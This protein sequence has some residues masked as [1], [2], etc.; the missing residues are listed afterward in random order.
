MGFTGFVSAQTVFGKIKDGVKKA[1]STV[2]QSIESIGDTAKST[3]DLAADGGTPQQSRESRDAVAKATLAQLFST[4]EEANALFMTS[5]GYAVFDTRKVIVLGVAAGFG[6]GVAVSRKT[7]ART[8]MNMGTG[9][10]GLSFGLG[11]FEKQIVIMFEKTAGF[12]SFIADGYDATAEAGAMLGDDKI[13]EG[14]RF[15]DGRSI[16]VLSKK[17][18]KVSTSAAGTKYWPDKDLN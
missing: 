15:V 5:A 3:T 9:G 17:G 16:F 8:Y 18:L 10:V 14:V 7:N 4:N 12:E 11:G 1:G 13:D 6:R 2:G